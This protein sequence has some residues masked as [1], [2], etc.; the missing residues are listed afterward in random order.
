MCVFQDFKCSPSTLCVV[1]TVT[2]IKAP[3]P[4]P[5]AVCKPSKL[6]RLRTPVVTT[7]ADWSGVH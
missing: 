6:C 1:E 5:K 7:E 4:G 2:C 3:C